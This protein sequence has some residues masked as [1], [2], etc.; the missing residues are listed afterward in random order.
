[1][2]LETPARA[3]TASMLTLSTPWRA[4]NSRAPDTTIVNIALDHLHTQFDTSIALTQ[5]VVTGYGVSV[6]VV[7]P[8]TRD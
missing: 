3:A 5:W 1:M 4:N 8:G 7:Q 6:R 2:R